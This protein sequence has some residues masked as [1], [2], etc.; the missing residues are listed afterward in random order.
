M[1]RCMQ[2]QPDFSAAKSRRWG[3]SREA[4]EEQAA[5]QQTAAPETARSD[6]ACDVL[7][8]SQAEGRQQEEQS[9]LHRAW[10]GM[11]GPALHDQIPGN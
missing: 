11:R 9:E 1:W 10:L 4:A 6:P 7:G 3:L 5:A 8:T 2:S